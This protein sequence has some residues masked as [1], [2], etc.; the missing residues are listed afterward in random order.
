MDAVAAARRNL[1]KLSRNSSEAEA[2]RAETKDTTRSTE[3][4]RLWK[5]KRGVRVLEKA[6]KKRE[7]EEDLDRRSDSSLS[8]RLCVAYDVRASSRIAAI[9][10]INRFASSVPFSSMT[11]SS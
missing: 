9:F 8:F 7:E 2:A 1:R 11:F 4:R 3:A 10:S 6:E 5:S